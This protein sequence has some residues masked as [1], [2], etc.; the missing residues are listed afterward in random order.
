MYFL[1]FCLQII[2]PELP[3]YVLYQLHAC[4]VLNFVDIDVDTVHK[5]K[6]EKEKN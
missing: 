2:L 6:K 5:T 3:F 4:G 1:V